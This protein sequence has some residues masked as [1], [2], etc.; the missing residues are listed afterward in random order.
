MAGAVNAIAPRMHSAI[1]GAL[2]NQ[3]PRGGSCCFIFKTLEAKIDEG[4][5]AA[6]GD[7]DRRQQQHRIE[8]G[9]SAPAAPRRE[10][11][12]LSLVQSPGNLEDVRSE[13]REQ[14]RRA[15]R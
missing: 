13:A 9:E 4:I 14:R 10:R 15:D 6:G 12:A 8:G 3:T 1:D 7:R 11:L 2:P 5:V